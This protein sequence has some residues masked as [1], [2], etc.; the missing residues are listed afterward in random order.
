MNKSFPAENKVKIAKIYSILKQLT[1]ET[2]LKVGVFYVKRLEEAINLFV[3]VYVN[4]DVEGFDK[5]KKVCFN[6]KKQENA[7][8]MK[9]GESIDDLAVVNVGILYSIDDIL[10]RS[11]ID[12]THEDYEKAYIKLRNSLVFGLFSTA[13]HELRHVMQYNYVMQKKEA[14]P[15]RRKLEGYRKLLGNVAEPIVKNFYD[16]S[17]ILGKEVGAF[18]ELLKSNDY[19]FSKIKTYCGGNIQHWMYM[20]SDEETDARNYETAKLN[21]FRAEVEKIGRHAE[22]QNKQNAILKKSDKVFLLGQK[23]GFNEKLR[24]ATKQ[25]TEEE[26]RF[27]GNDAS[28]MKTLEKKAK[29]ISLEEIVQ[30]T[31][32]MSEN[33]E[34]REF[35]ANAVKLFHR[36]KLLSHIFQNEEKVSLLKN[37]LIKEE[38]YF[39]IDMIDKRRGE[40]DLCI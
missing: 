20:I 38:L 7:Q 10:K 4:P 23:D 36:G 5:L 27:S 25:K 3:E 40:V 39:A 15:D 6:E 31:R 35:F 33:R 16:D 2:S 29:E 26:R 13:A 28:L 32:D 18:F 1:N 9:W 8:G 34:K 24:K 11:G 17:R 22:K 37:M 12:K 19:D 14:M 30:F 21:A